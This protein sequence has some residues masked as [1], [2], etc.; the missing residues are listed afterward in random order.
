MLTKTQKKTLDFIKSYIDTHE[1]SPTLTEIASGIGIQS[2]GTVSRYIQALIDKGYLSKNKGYSRSLK[3]TGQANP[4]SH[5]RQ[6]PLLGSIAA[7]NPILAIE[8]NDNPNLSSLLK[9][10]DLFMLEIKGNSMV[11]LGIK[12]GDYVICEKQS[13]ARQGDIVVALVDNEEATLK[14]LKLS[15]N[16]KVLLCPANSDYEPIEIDANRVK[17][18]GILRAQLRT[19]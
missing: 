1:I 12:D 18:Q 6:V 3:L 2:K 13:S 7:G 19:F 16:G 17:I 14:R 9:G 8:Q 11:D 5:Q 4:H 10:D 15:D